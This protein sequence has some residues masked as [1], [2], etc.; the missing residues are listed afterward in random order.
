MSFIATHGLWT[1]SQR[2]RAADCLE[3]VRA[4]AI[5]SIRVGFVDLH[6]IVRGKVVTAATIAEVM[7]SGL[8]ITSSLL[9]KDTAHRTVGQIFTPG[10]GAGVRGFEGAADLMLVPDPDSFRILPWAEKTAW[11]LCDAYFPDGSPV[12]YAPR[13]ILERQTRSLAAR[14]LELVVGLEIEFHVF[15]IDDPSL[16]LYQSGQPG[17]PPAVSL[18]HQGYNYLTEQRYDMVEPLMEIL[19]G[20]CAALGLPLRSM[21]IEFGPSQIEFVF[22]AAPAARSADDMILFR[23]AIKQVCQRH[24]FHATFMCRPA[25][26]NVCSS[27]WHLHQSI[28]RRS[29]G[30]NLFAGN[31]RELLSAFGM[32]YLSGLLRDA[33]ACMPLST[34]TINGYKRIRPLSLAPDRAA[35][36]SDN[37]GAMLRVLSGTRSARIENRIGEPAANPYLYIASQVICGMSGVDEGLPPPPAATSPYESEAPLLP[38]TLAEAVLALDGSSRLRQALG[39]EFIDH[40]LRIKRAEVARFNAEVSA[41]EQREYFELF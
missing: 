7:S 25:I 13:Q 2:D 10:G 16:A 5:E 18:T 30:G 6:G 39:N 11:L 15:R 20:T 19:R 26:P 1:A 3:R 4:D 27:G 29:D 31:D 41:W 28:R 24:G 23:T 14:D 32:G 38:T 36:G 9:L 22:D 37:R 40:L 21:E 12:A 33:D 8:S 17:Q 35:W 34:P